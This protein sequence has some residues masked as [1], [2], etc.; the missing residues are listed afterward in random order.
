MKIYK[1]ET[2]TQKVIKAFERLI[3]QLSSDCALPTGEN[4][5][6]IINSEHTRL[7]LVEKNNEIVGTLSLVYNSIPTGK[8]AWIEDVVVDK[9][10][11]GLGI[12]KELIRYAVM[13]SKDIG[14]EK[15]N[16][17]SSPERI[18]ANKMYKKLGFIKRDTNV[19]RL[20]VK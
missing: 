15:I 2:V 10:V 1:L 11:R 12:G 20:E 19:Y 16:L 8:K 4:L 9:S 7:F 5:E 18:A 13:Y 6:T 17:T 3:P 14:I